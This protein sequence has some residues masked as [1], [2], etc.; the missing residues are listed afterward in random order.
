MN[1]QP[2]RC[3]RIVLLA[4]AGID[5]HEIARRLQISRNQAMAWRKRFAQ[6]GIAAICR[7]AD[8]S[9]VRCGPDRAGDDP[10]AA[11]GCHLLEHAH[12]G[13]GCVRYHRAEGLVRGRAQAAP[14]TFK[15][16]RAPQF[17]ERVEDIIG[18]YLMPS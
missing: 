8:A 10:D 16:L 2:V 18:L 7:A 5:N 6:G 12:N 3:A 17:V 13:A 4:A 14:G 9:G 15:V 11:R 1:A